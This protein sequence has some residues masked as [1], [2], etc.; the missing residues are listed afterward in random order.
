MMS[1]KKQQQMHRGLAVRFCH[2]LF[3]NDTVSFIICMVCNVWCFTLRNLLALCVMW[4]ELNKN[5]K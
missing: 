1:K 5:F 3:L 4:S 2:S